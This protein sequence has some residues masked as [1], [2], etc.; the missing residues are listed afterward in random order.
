[1]SALINR[2]GGGLIVLRRT[3][4]IVGIQAL[5][6]RIGFAFVPMRIMDFDR[7]PMLLTI[8]GNCARLRCSFELTYK[9]RLPW[10]AD[11]IY[12]DNVM[13]QASPET[14]HPRGRYVGRNRIEGK[15]DLYNSK[16]TGEL[17]AN[18][19]RINP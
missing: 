18:G 6:G 5:N 7:S 4:Y 1:M 14:S 13:Q 2:R 8:R 12:A 10:S 17:T 11:A 19:R 3:T 15:V 16:V 9:G